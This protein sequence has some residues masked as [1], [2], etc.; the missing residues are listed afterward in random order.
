MWYELTTSGDSVFCCDLHL[1]IVTQYWQQLEEYKKH[2]HKCVILPRLIK[3][4][5]WTCGE[6]YYEQLIYDNTPVVT[7]DLSNVKK[8]KYGKN[9][10]FYKPD[11]K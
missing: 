3:E 10:S 8:Y 6:C 1:K 5:Q 7:T 2:P 4:P 11:S 9:I